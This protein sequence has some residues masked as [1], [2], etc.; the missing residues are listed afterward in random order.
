MLSE[1]TYPQFLEW[2]AYEALEPWGP[3]RLEQTVSMINQTLLNTHRAKGKPPL[4]LYQVMPYFGD[5]VV[6]KD[7]APKRS[8]AQ[9]LDVVRGIVKTQK[10]LR[11]QEKARRR[12]SA[13]RRRRSQKLPTRG[14]VRR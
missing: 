1:I 6:S 7:M 9:L 10:M 8:S 2:M 13:Q 3:E 4:N 11:A 5:A 14:T 12:E